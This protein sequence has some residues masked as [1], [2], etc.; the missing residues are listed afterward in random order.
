MKLKRRN[1]I[2]YSTITLPQ[3]LN[4]QLQTLAAARGCTKA[5]LV[6]YL[7]EYKELQHLDD[8]L[9]DLRQQ[10]LKGFN[11]TQLVHLSVLYTMLKNYALRFNL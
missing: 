7:I 5:E 4:Q 3:E 8:L 10:E 1:N 9:V 6:T 2:A 11:I